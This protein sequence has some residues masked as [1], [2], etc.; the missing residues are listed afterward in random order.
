MKNAAH[1]K[2]EY[3]NIVFVAKYFKCIVLYNV[4]TN[5]AIPLKESFYQCFFFISTKILISFFVKQNDLCYTGY[6]HITLKKGAATHVWHQQQRTALCIIMCNF[7]FYLEKI[8]MK[9]N[10]TT[11]QKAAVYSFRMIKSHTFT[12]WAIA[13]PIIFHFVRSFEHKN[14]RK[15]WNNTKQF[16]IFIFMQVSCTAKLSAFFRFRSCKW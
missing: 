4:Q 5:H 12:I 8:K 3:K 7:G 9:F 13:K 6:M 14:W 10:D 15:H 2:F 1:T 16:I 11:E